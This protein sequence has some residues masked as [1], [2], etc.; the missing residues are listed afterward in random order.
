MS[1]FVLDTGFPSVHF[2]KLILIFLLTVELVIS[3]NTTQVSGGFSI[4]NV[5]NEYGLDYIG[6]FC[7]INTNRPK[8]IT[9]YGR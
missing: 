7:L 5:Q 3:G 2:V 1:T 9:Q 8:L 6:K 4:R